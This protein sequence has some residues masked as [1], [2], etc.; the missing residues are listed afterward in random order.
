M[1][2][3]RL[4]EMHEKCSVMVTDRLGSEILFALPV[5]DERTGSTSYARTFECAWLMVRFHCTF[6]SEI[7]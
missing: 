1:Q 3:M 6:D 2:S 4:A 5:G 7:A